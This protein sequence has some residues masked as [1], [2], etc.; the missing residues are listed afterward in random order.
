MEAQIE[1]NLSANKLMTQMTLGFAG[2]AA[3][4]AGIGLYGVLAYNVARRTREI[5]IRMAIGAALGLAGGWAVSRVVTSQLN[6][7]TASDPL[8][9]AA[10]LGLLGLI[11]L[12]A[13]YVPTLRATRVDPITAL[14]Y[15]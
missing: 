4:L 2:L 10:A 15:E 1:E 6:D 7:M 9:F 3:L 11:A 14:R 5:G 8:I 13:A 12:I